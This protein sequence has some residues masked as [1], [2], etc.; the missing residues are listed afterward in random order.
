[1]LL[2]TFLFIVLPGSHCYA[3]KESKLVVKRKSRQSMSP[4]AQK[5]Q[6]YFKHNHDSDDSMSLKLAKPALA[7]EPEAENKNRDFASIAALKKSHSKKNKLLVHKKISKKKK[8]ASKEKPPK[9]K[10]KI[11]VTKQKGKSRRQVASKGI[12]RKLPLKKSKDND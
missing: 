11:K 1:M 10:G 3:K 7:K 5:A 6:E 2:L 4:G 8:I 12:P 9:L